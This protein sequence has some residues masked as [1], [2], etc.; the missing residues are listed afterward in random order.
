MPEPKYTYGIE[1]PCG[2]KWNRF[3]KEETRPYCQG[4]F[5]ALKGQAPSLA[6]RL[7]RS[8]GK[9]LDEIKAYDSVGLGMIAGFPTAEQYERAAQEALDKAARIRENQKRLDDRRNPK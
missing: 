2:D 8:D 6:Y 1:C 9:I 3:I 7:V 5:N 4:Y